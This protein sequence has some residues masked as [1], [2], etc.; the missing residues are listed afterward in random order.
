MKLKILPARAGYLWVKSGFA[1]FAYRP[2]SFLGF[3]ISFLLAALLLSRIPLVGPYL[4]MLTPP[5]LILGM[6]AVG[7]ECVK[8]KTGL[9]LP[10]TPPPFVM[11]WMTVRRAIK[12]LFQLG[13]WY[14]FLCTAVVMLSSLVDDGAFIKDIN[15]VTKGVAA[16]ASKE[17]EKHQGFMFVLTLLM[18][19]LTVVFWF[20]PAL[21]N[22]N[23]FTLTKSLFFSAYAVLKN[24]RAF[25]TYFLLW[26]GIFQIFTS[27]LS[28]VSG[29]DIQILISLLF[30][31]SLVFLSIFLTSALPTFVDCFQ[32]QVPKA[33][34]A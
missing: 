9:V 3:F 33:P 13:I 18:L 11:G 24:W 34:S 29:G 26:M 22:W 19:P 5:A 12:P 21:M 23:Q 30:S 7:N 1:L 32:H 17:A 27:V 31:G 15:E 16:T 8:I 6:M 10:M 14:A 28:L 2:F 25:G 4:L 20:A